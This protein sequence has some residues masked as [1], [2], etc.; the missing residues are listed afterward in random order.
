LSIQNDGHLSR[1]EG[2]IREPG[3]AKVST[4]CKALFIRDTTELPRRGTEESAR[5]TN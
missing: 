2:V 3:C 4:L 1:S 5:R